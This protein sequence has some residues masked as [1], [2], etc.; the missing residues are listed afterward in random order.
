MARLRGVFTPVPQPRQRV[1]LGLGDVLQERAGVIGR[2]LARMTLAME[3]EEVARPLG[4]AF[5][6]LRPPQVLMGRG[7]D[8]LEQARRLWQ[9]EIG[10]VS[11]GVL[12]WRPG[13]FG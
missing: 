11:H 1:L 12:L 5:A 8:L 10:R 9:G 4:V 3:Q 13:D 2:V 7:P 6:G